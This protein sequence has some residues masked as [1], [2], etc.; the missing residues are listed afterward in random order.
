ML[1]F[2]FYRGV[3][4]LFN[5][6]RKQQ[7]DVEDQLTEAGSSIRKKDKIMKSVTKGA[8]LD[9][10]KGTKV[11]VSSQEPEKNN[12]EVPYVNRDNNVYI[13]IDQKQY[14]CKCVTYIF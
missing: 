5:A 1:G 8:F 4:Q 11:N 2:I 14:E 9:L 12:M 10:L 3:V 6:V 13:S 7:K